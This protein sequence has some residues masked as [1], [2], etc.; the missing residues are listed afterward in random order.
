[1]AEFY[2]ACGHFSR[3]LGRKISVVTQ[4]D[5]IEFGSKHQVKVNFNATKKATGAKEVYVFHGT[6]DVNVKS[7]ITEGFKV[8][9][10]GVPIA[11]GAAYGNGVYTATGPSTPMGYTH[12]A[13]KIFLARGLVLN[14]DISV[15]D[16]IIFKSG[17]QLL[18]CYVVH[19]GHDSGAIPTP[20]NASL[21]PPPLIGVGAALSSTG[22]SL[23]FHRSNVLVIYCWAVLL[24]RYLLLFLCWLSYLCFSGWSIWKYLVQIF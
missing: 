3:L 9:G 7:I 20:A 14:S 15:N 19:F 2:N 23:F 24:Y 18:P 11:N 21:P 13:N 10:A 12:G 17:K 22:I 6:R 5:V 4:V 1:M 8:G 16:W